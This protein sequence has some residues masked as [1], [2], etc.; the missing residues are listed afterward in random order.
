MPL[1]R[2]EGSAHGTLGNILLFM[3][4][5]FFTLDS[6]GLVMK[7]VSLY[8]QGNLQL[9]TF[10]RQLLRGSSDSPRWS[11]ENPSSRYE[12]IGLVDHDER[13]DE[14]DEQHNQH[15]VVFAVGEDESDSEDHPEQQQ[16]RQPGLPPYTGQANKPRRPSLLIR[17]WT[18]PSRSSTGS[19]GT[20]QDTP[21]LSGTSGPHPFKHAS[22]RSGAYDQPHAEERH[23]GGEWTDVHR[24]TEKRLTTRRFLAIVLTWV[25]RS[26]VVL[27][28][29]TFLTGFAVYTVSRT[30]FCLSFTLNAGNSSRWGRS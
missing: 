10:T 9:S 24:T 11:D 2:Y 22:S 21:P 3:S 4:L 5:G 13:D 29:A 19:E 25:R 6:F 28:Y 20:L 8:R 14:H 23:H 7:A 1:V 27:A 18:P 26:Q 30:L 16:H 17:K 15:Q 12:M